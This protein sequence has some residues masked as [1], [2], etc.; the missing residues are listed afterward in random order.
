MFKW[1]EYVFLYGT[2][3]D[4]YKHMYKNCMFI[5]F[6]FKH[7]ITICVCVYVEH[8]HMHVY[9]KAGLGCTNIYIAEHC[10]FHRSEDVVN[11]LVQAR[12]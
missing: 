5:Y 6:P 8:I 10:T 11:Q 9:H 2:M 12:R 1:K 4:T 7:F 3:Y